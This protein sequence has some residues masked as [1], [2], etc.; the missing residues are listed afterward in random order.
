M[1]AGLY[2]TLVSLLFFQRSLFL[3]LNII[4]TLVCIEMLIMMFYY[5]TIACGA[6]FDILF[7]NLLLV[8]DMLCTY[9]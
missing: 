7:G 6:S 3:F 2:F 9:L 8:N 5:L 1:D 4:F